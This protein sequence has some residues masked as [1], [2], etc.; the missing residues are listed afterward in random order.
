MV[1]KLKKLG[2]NNFILF[3]NY[4]ELKILTK[5]VKIVKKKIKKQYLKKKNRYFFDV[6]MYTQK[7]KKIITKAVNEFKKI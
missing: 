3:N 6:L 2:Y 1:T 4:G 5:N 7:N